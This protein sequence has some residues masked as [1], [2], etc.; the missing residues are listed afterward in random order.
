MK[1]GGRGAVCVTFHLRAQTFGVCECGC[2]KLGGSQRSKV[3]CLKYRKTATPEDLCK[4]LLKA[5]EAA[6]QQT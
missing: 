4:K 6:R 5:L 2:V 3:K 1:G